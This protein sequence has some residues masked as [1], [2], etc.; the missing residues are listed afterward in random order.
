MKYGLDASKR[1]SD[2]PEKTL[3]G[4]PKPKLINKPTV[5]WEKGWAPVK[6]QWTISE[7][8]GNNQGTIKEQSGN[9]QGTI[10]EQSGNNQ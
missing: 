6:V 9:N 5:T 10:R 7:Q 3:V 1:A 2:R 8:P 4:P